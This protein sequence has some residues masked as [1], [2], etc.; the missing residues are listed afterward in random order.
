VKEEPACPS[1]P[2]GKNA[3]HCGHH[4]GIVSTTYPSMSGAVCCRCGATG[5]YRKGRVLGHGPHA[6]AQFF[7]LPVEWDERPKES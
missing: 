1:S 2:Y 5:L 6:P 7:E 4:S 3:P